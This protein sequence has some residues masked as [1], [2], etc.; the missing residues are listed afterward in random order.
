MCGNAQT[1]QVT[2][3]ILMQS[4]KII[5]TTKM[6]NPRRNRLIG[7]LPEKDYSRLLPFL[8][9]VSLEMG[10]ELYVMGQRVEHIYFPTTALISIAKDLTDGLGVDTAIVGKNSAVGLL[11]LDTDVSI[12]RAHVTSSGFAYRINR[13]VLLNEIRRGEAMFEIWMAATRYLANQLSQNVVCNRFHSVEQRLARWLLTNADR[14]ETNLIPVTH[15]YLSSSIGVRRETVSLTGM[16][17]NDSGVVRCTRGSTE[18][19]D[20]ERLEAMSCECYFTLR[21]LSPFRKD[22]EFGMAAQVF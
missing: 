6:T 9:L 8:Q 14:L 1:G 18:V 22:D 17:M 4:I 12:N 3:S 11:L 5:E 10:Q 7:A 13:K 20:R 15:G 2:I 21:K 19:L 16:K